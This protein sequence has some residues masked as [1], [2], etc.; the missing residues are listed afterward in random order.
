MKTVLDAGFISDTAMVNGASLHY[1]RGGEGPPLI[2]VYGFPQ[3]WSEYHAIMPDLAKQFT[4]IAV[5]LRGIGES[6]VQSGG[7]DAANMAEDIYQLASTLG[8][9]DLYVVGHDLGGMVAY[10]FVRRYPELLAGAM[11]LDQVIPGI[12]GWE[13]VQNSQPYGIFTLCSFPSFPR[14]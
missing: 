2:L 9:K 7:Y 3:D 11:I 12:D 4:V 1:L 8:L 6:T 13:Q 10:A 14:S 5:D